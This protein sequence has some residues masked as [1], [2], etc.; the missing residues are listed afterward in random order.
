MI[1]SAGHELAMFIMSVIMGAMG[2][3]IYDIVRSLRRGRTPNI[4]FDLLLWAAEGGF[5]L[6]WWNE[7][8]GG[9]IR[10]YMIL[11]CVLGAV[12][13]F[14]LV[15]PWLFASLDFSVKKIYSF[16]NIILKFLLT[17]AKFF[18]KIFLYIKNTCGLK[19]YKKVD[20]GNN[21]KKA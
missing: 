20:E 5:A 19:Y 7:Y 8:L 17:A 4:F 3:V 15:S 9:V 21:E 18:G 1:D 2:I 12:L 13:C 10:W 11:G 16:F 6:F 14:F